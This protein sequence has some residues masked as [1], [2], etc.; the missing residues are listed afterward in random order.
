M[1]RFAKIFVDQTPGPKSDS[2]ISIFGIDKP[3]KFAD[4]SGQFVQ[5]ESLQK[6]NLNDSG[7]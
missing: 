4:L 2:G 7:L 1:E 3:V 6:P 5:P